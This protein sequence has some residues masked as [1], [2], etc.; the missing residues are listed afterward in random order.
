MSEKNLKVSV[1]LDY[2]GKLL[3]QKQLDVTELYYNEDLSL[4]EISE[5]ENISRQGVRDSIKRAEAFLFELEDKLEMVKKFS[6][7]SDSLERINTLATAALDG[8][9]GDVK[10]SFAKIKNEANKALKIV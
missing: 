10:E 8:G 5:L 4:G 9:S 7:V 3:T 2:Y 1:L 6:E